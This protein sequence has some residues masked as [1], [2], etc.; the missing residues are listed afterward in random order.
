MDGLGSETGRA[1]TPG[2]SNES[3]LHHTR[4]DRGASWAAQFGLHLFHEL[5]HS[6]AYAHA[7]AQGL[8][9]GRTTQLQSKR[10]LFGL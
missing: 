1:R 4:V 9:F 7:I 3:H 5:H 2:K 6:G 10:G 8:L